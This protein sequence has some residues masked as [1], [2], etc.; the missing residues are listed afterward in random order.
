MC[1]YRGRAG[2]YCFDW[3]TVP[4]SERDRARAEAGAWGSLGEQF[5]TV[6]DIPPEYDISWI[7]DW[8]VD[9]WILRT[10]IENL[11]KTTE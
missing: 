11:R 10:T 3:S 1:L 5:K 2:W 8:H 7:C 4:P 9:R 6:S